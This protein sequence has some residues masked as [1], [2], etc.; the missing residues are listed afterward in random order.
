[1]AEDDVGRST[2][3]DRVWRSSHE[4]TSWRS[5]DID[6]DPDARA[7]DDW[8]VRHQAST[9]A[10][11]LDDWLSSRQEWPTQWRD[12]ADQSDY[13]PTTSPFPSTADPRPCTARASSAPSV[14]GVSFGAVFQVEV[15]GVTEGAQ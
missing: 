3:R 2:G 6:D 9:A 5:T 12:A 1:M 7:A 10:N 11:W 13:L 4:S 15:I 8:L 14:P